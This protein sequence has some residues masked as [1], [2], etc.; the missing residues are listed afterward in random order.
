MSYKTDTIIWKAQIA[1]TVVHERRFAKA[2]RK[3]FARQEKEVLR[4]VQKSNLSKLST[5]TKADEFDTYLSSINLDEEQWNKTFISSM[6]PFYES[7]ALAAGQ[8]AMTDIG[9]GVAF[10]VEDVATKKFINDKV[11]NFSGFVN[12]ETNAG[13]NRLIKPIIKRG[14]SIEDVRERIQK[15]V[16]K[17]FNS[18]VRGTAPRARMIAR[19]E[20]VGTANGSSL[21]AARQSGTVKFKAWLDSRDKRVRTDHRRA[22]IKYRRKK[23]IPLEQPFIVGRGKTRAKLKSP[24][25]LISGNAGQV[26]N[27]RCTIIFTRT[28][29]GKPK[30]VEGVIPEP[31]P[32][33]VT[34][35]VPK[36]TPRTRQFVKQFEK[37]FGDLAS[38]TVVLNRAFDDF[39]SK[40]KT[41]SVG[42]PFDTLEDIKKDFINDWATS[43]NGGRASILK[44]L[45]ETK[46]KT[47]T[48][49][50][51]QFLNSDIDR[52]R[53]FKKEVEEELKKAAAGTF[54]MPV[55]DYKKQLS[56]T[57]DYLQAFSS[58][59]SKK[60]G[61]KKV[62]LYRG[63]NSAYFKSKN[64]TDPLKLKN[65]F[66]DIN[67]LSSWSIEKDRAGRFGK[68]IFK[69]EVDAD[70]VF[71]SH[72]TD[73]ILARSREKEF[74]VRRNKRGFRLLD[75]IKQE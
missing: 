49:F 16:V 57:M 21:E 4:K 24:G 51:G 67:S 58:F 35:D 72:L 71:T 9:A 15:S 34:S 56:R 52:I 37:E 8:S 29:I 44:S 5:V 53:R 50:D 27:C 43:S 65:T 18:S 2:L 17:R 64:I 47:K 36:L 3:L 73:S 40:R 66:L 10:D 13:L 20:M 22:G 45:T 19:T 68:F 14:G 75:V 46:Y 32:A 25:V 70:D 23:A 74:I 62:I 1:Q 30:P 61:K 41:G 69:I 55:K 11:I 33:E 31:A 63:I 39:L 28:G 60:L 6:K 7:M 42:R 59:A 26:I 54:R 38:D 12:G 48:L